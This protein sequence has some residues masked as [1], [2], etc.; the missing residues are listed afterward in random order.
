MSSVHSRPKSNLLSRGAVLV[1]FLLIL[2]LV[3]VLL[4]LNGPSMKAPTQLHG[5]TWSSMLAS[6]KSAASK[7]D[8]KALLATSMGSDGVGADIQGTQPLLEWTPT[9]TLEVHFDFLKPNGD[10]INLRLLSDNPTT[11]LT[12]TFYNVDPPNPANATSYRF[13]TQSYDHDQVLMEKMQVSPED[14]FQITWPLA[15]AAGKEHGLAQGKQFYAYASLNVQSNDWD[16]RLGTINWEV[17]YNLR[18]P[19]PPAP[20]E[21]EKMNVYMEGFQLHYSVDALT[22]A[23]TNVDSK[24]K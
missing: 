6:A 3:S 5:D 24:N 14:A 19:L 18:T 2:G 8:K 15:Y 23:I 20:T 17:Y 16:W 12:P 11:I 4:V 10:G 22:G 9:T 13:A 1:G 7:L 21:R